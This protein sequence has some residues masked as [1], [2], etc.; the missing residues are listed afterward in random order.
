MIANQGSILIILFEFR[1]INPQYFACRKK[2]M[3][4]QQSSIYHIDIESHMGYREYE[5]IEFHCVKFVT[6]PQDQL[7]DS[8]ISYKQ[9]V[10]SLHDDRKR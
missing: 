1:T 9:N 10:K 6:T 7:S 3:E 4:T 5:V 2:K 8:S